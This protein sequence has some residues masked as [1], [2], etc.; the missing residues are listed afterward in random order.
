MMLALGVVAIVIFALGFV[1]FLRFAPPDQATGMHA[2][3]VGIFPY[4]P[5]Q[6]TV[7][8]P[9]SMRFPRGEPF[10]ARVNWAD[11]PSRVVVGAQWYD[12]LDEAVGG[13]APA[14]AADLAARD[15]L[16]AVRTPPGFHENLPGRYTLAVVR[17]AAGRP[18]ELLARRTVR[19]EPG[20]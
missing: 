15:A 20:P 9:A 7:H 8:G 2:Q 16:V 12:S 14:P 17:Y 19:V 13:V 1:I 11:L 4:D 5:V 3:V 18:V 6:R 10:A